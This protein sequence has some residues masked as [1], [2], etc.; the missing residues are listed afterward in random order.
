MHISVEMR[1]YWDLYYLGHCSNL[2]QYF[3]ILWGE[4][5]Y[6]KQKIPLCAQSS[7]SCEQNVKMAF[8]LMQ[9]AAECCNDFVL[10]FNFSCYVVS[11][12]RAA[13]I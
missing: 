10:E 13:L 6:G 4:P 12:C 3:V 8:I 2:L 7:L 11:V 5:T 9:T 1:N